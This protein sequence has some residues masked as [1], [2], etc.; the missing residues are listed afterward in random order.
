M[1]SYPGSHEKGSFK[2]IFNYRLSRARW[3]VEHVFGILSAVFRVLRKP[4][5]IEPEKVEIV[6]V[7]CTY[8]HHFLR[9]NQSLKH[10][11]TSNGTYIII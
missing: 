9:K 11:Y 2:R 5:L 8:L 4:L 6:V 1:K 10:I 3:I 7:A